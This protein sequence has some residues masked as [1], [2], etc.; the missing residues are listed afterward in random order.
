MMDNIGSLGSSVLPYRVRTFE[1]NLARY[2]NNLLALIERLLPV[3]FIDEAAIE[4]E[5][6][7]EVRLREIPDNS[8][9]DTPIST[10]S[11]SVHHS[12]RLAKEIDW[13]ELDVNFSNDPDVPFPFRGRVIRT[14]LQRNLPVLSVR[15]DEKVLAAIRQGPI[16]AMSVNGAAKHFRSALPLPEIGPDQ[17]FSDVFNGQ[18]F[19]EMLPLMHFFR[20]IGAISYQPPPLRAGF[21]IDD[22]NLHWTRYGYID[23]R[24]VVSHAK[25]WNYHMSFAT[26]PLDTWYT[27]SKAAELFRHNSRWLSLL[28]H[29]NNHGKNE[30]AINHADPVRTAL[31]QQAIRRIDRLERRGKQ[32]VSRVMVPPHGAC[33]SEMLAALPRCGFE[34]ACISSGSLRA[35]NRNHPWTKTLGYFPSENIE[36]CPVLPRWGLTGN[37]KNALLIA[38]YLGQPMILRGHHQDFRDGIEIFDEFATFINGLG[39]VFWSNMTDLSRLNYLWRMEGTT[40]HLKPLGVIIAFQPPS[41]AGEI[42]IDKFNASDDYAWRLVLPGGSIHKVDLIQPIPLD[43]SAGQKLILQRVIGE[44]RA[45]RAPSISVHFFLRRLL[46]E[47][48]DRLLIA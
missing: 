45:T 37:V 7:G 13:I 35:H 4:S 47:M 31:L 17:N 36:G 5:I 8:I 1:I 46:T 10:C 42:V 12:A 24:A 2:S 15:K 20:E 25:V 38:A 48:R 11:F 19:L 21:I 43:R 28:I 3:R 40:C 41:E 34:S 26:I 22:P 33:S 14:Y 9:L 6:A 27:N 32:H 30:L 16:W 18:R 39:D 29:G 44:Q 23:F